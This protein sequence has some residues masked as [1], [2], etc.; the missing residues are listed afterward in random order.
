MLSEITAC[1]VLFVRRVWWPHITTVAEVLFRVRV[2][3]AKSLSLKTA[4]SPADCMRRDC[5]TLGLCTKYLTHLF[6]CCMSQTL[7]ACMH[8]ASSLLANCRSGLS[9]AR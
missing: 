1:V 8:L 2:H 9:K 4:S 5:T 6:N 3:P 7:G